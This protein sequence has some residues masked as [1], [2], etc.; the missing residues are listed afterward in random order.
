VGV[1]ARRFRDTLPAV[2]SERMLH[3]VETFASFFAPFYFFVAG[4]GLRRDDFSVTS[5]GIG[6]LLV[7]IMGPLRVASVAGQRRLALRE[8]W[9]ESLRVAVPLLPTLV[10]T[11]V[12]AGIMRD[13]FSVGSPL[14]GA[15]IVYAVVNTLLP[16]FVFR[17]PTPVFDAPVLDAPDA[18]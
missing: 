13:Q 2:A 8:S 6:L 10:F 15:L 18:H 3:A 16:G 12:V 5:V 14:Y 1:A 4:S 11:L 9:R 17:T 7:A